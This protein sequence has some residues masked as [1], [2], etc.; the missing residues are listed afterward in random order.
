M[1]RNIVN[2]IESKLKSMSFLKL[3]MLS[4]VLG[5]GIS[6]IFA[7]TRDIFNMFN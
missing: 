2:Q 3:T 1:E 4:V 6:L 5:G 7:I